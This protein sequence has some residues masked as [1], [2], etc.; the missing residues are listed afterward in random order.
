MTFQTGQS[1]VHKL[2][3]VVKLVWLLSVTVA[4]FAFN[5]PV[6]PAVIVAVAAG[7]LWHAGVAP[8]RLP[9]A[10]LWLTL[11]L[12]IFIAQI[13]VVRDG[14]PVLGLFTTGGLV[15]GGRALGRLLAVI[16]ASAL[17][18]VTTE[19]VTLACALMRVGL[20][21][22][23]GF[24]LVTA[25]R[26]APVFRIEAHHVYRAQLARGVA[27]DARGPRR[28]WLLL[29]HLSM[30]LLVSALRTAHT[31][32]LS[33]EGRAFGLYPQRTSSRE[34]TFRIGDAVALA[35]LPLSAALAVWLQ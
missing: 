10:R 5:S 2:H 34:I 15:A 29:R 31:L 14:E 11:G 1:L 25:L 7:L 19:P 33:M 18:V 21:C 8:W 20:P 32:S 27:Y 16:L 13:V 35:L 22:R 24:A 4:V 30:P 17:F 9:A 3:P 6:L 23:W 28:W 26:L 12:A